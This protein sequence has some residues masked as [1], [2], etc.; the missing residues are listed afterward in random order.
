MHL[1]FTTKTLEYLALEGCVR[2]IA[3][4]EERDWEDMYWIARLRKQTSGRN[5]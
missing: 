1:E 3:G 4:I 2:L 5:L